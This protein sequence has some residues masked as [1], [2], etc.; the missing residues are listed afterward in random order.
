MMCR[1][2]ERSNIPSCFIEH[3]A[4][5]IDSGQAIAKLDELVQYCEAI[6]SQNG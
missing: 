2:A 3:I 1:S 5:I 4:A 6:A